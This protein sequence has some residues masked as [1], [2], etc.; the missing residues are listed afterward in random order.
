MLPI[1]QL[2]SVFCPP[3][4]PSYSSVLAVGCIPRRPSH[5]PVN[6]ESPL[7]TSGLPLMQL[8]FSVPFAKFARRTHDNG[9]ASPFVTARPQHTSYRPSVAL[10]TSATGSRF[11]KDTSTPALDRFSLESRPSHDITV[12]SDR[13]LHA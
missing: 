4:S 9:G 2:A 6:R 5:E 11:N 12:T 1:N 8:S 13:R 10:L 3:L 7:L